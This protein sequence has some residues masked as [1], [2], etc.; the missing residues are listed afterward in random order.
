MRNGRR[1]EEDGA[2]RTW[3]RQEEESGARARGR[4]RRNTREVRGGGE[5]RARI[6]R[7]AYTRILFQYFKRTPG[8]H[9]YPRVDGQYLKRTTNVAWR[10]WLPSP[11]SSSRERE[12]NSWRASEKNCRLKLLISFRSVH[13]FF[14]V[15]LGWKCVWTG[16]RPI[17]D[18]R[19]VIVSI[20]ISLSKSL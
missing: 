1:T 18:A 11:S 8:Y 10:G 19:L 6:R 17:S 9:A 5:R 13:R 14:H 16:Y 4:M 7:A 20:S 12:T 3:K 15:L 2:C